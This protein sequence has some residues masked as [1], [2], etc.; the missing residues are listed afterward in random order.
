ML[1]K[2]IVKLI[3]EQINAE[4]YSAYLYLDFANYYYEVGLDGFANWYDIQVK[5]EFDHAMLMRQYMHNN[6][7]TVKFEAIAKPDQKYSNHDDPLKEGLEHERYITSLI[8]KIYKT[9]TELDDFRT[10]HFLNW[11][12]DEQGEEE[13]NASDLLTKYQLFAS[14]PNGLYTLDKDLKT[15][16]YNPPSLVLD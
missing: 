3:N 14:T 15:R 11:F 5:E 13:K 6:D 8:N 4:L 10:I 12:V 2:K 9:A 7:E 16:T 1:D